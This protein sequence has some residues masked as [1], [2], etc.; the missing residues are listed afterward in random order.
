MAALL[1][2]WLASYATSQSLVRAFSSTSPPSSG[3]GRRRGRGGSKGD[4]SRELVQ[5]L[6]EAAN[7][8]DL[9]RLLDERDVDTFAVTTAMGKLRR[10]GKSKEALQLFKRSKARGIA[11][12]VFTYTAAIAACGRNWKGALAL[13]DELQERGLEPNI[14]TYSAL[15]S[16]CEK[17]GQW[18]K[19]MEV[20]HEL[21]SKGLA[22]NA[23]SYNALISGAETSGRFD[24]ARA[25]LFEA[26]AGGC[27]A[28]L[29]ASEDYLDLGDLK[30]AVAR[31]AL[32]ATLDDD[33]ALLEGD[34]VVVVAG[35]AAQAIVALLADE[36]PR[37]H[38]A[39]DS[40]NPARLVLTS[41]PPAI[42]D[43]S[44]SELQQTT[45][46]SA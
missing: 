33:D 40:K 38:C 21:R 11:L 36:Y 2:T 10:F 12:N 46:R 14:V 9:F 37:L 23:R 7:A 1:V 5:K 22:P 26:I 3:G 45:T 17:G 16:A 15:I 35:D 30:P 31:T 13:F 27:Y 42:D 29:E 18:D 34:F 41:L 32:R 6:K 19:A 39:Q 24:E 4:R 44:S 20:F 43:D 8:E 25:F 28:S